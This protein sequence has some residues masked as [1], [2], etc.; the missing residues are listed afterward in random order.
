MRVVKTVLL[1][2]CVL[3]TLTQ[4][5]RLFYGLTFKVQL[6]GLGNSYAVGSVLGGL[7]SILLGYV[8]SRLLWKSLQKDLAT[9]EETGNTAP[10]PEV[11]K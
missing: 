7:F 2:L 3:Y 11:P 8:L 6:M 5:L 1:V 4:A 10:I 9:D